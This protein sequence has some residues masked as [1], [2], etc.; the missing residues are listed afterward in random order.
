MLVG[1]MLFFGGE[2]CEALFSWILG[3][4][5]LL[6]LLDKL[7]LRFPLLIPFKAIQLP[8]IKY[9][10]FEETINIGHAQTGNITVYRSFFSSSKYKYA[11]TWLNFIFVFLNYL[12]RNLGKALGWVLMSFWTV[13]A[14]LA[15]HIH[16]LAINFRHWFKC[17]RLLPN[18]D[19][20]ELALAVLARDIPNF[21]LINLAQYIEINTFV[22]AVEKHWESS[23]VMELDLPDQIARIYEINIENFY[24]AQ[25]ARDKIRKRNWMI[26]LVICGIFLSPLSLL[27][28][29]PRYKNAF[30]ED[31]IIRT[32]ITKQEWNERIVYRRTVNI[33]K[34]GLRSA[35]DKY[36]VARMMLDNNAGNLRKIYALTHM[37]SV[38]KLDIY[39][40]YA[41]KTQVQKQNGKA[42]IRDIVSKA[43]SLNASRSGNVNDTFAENMLNE[44]E[45]IYEKHASAVWFSVGKDLIQSFLLNLAACAFIC[46][47]PRKA[48]FYAGKLVYSELDTIKQ[49]KFKQLIMD[50]SVALG[51]KLAEEMPKVDPEIDKRNKEIRILHTLATLSLIPESHAEDDIHRLKALYF[52]E[53]LTGGL[54]GLNTNAGRSSLASIK[55]H[56]GYV[57]LTQKLEETKASLLA[58]F[59]NNP[60]S[61]NHALHF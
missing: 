7:Q 26:G 9:F 21:S 22:A 60:R 53:L 50:V 44:M 47:A 57:D 14:Y 25:L 55:Q 29:I 27:I 4:A 51:Q 37:P 31:G 6:R 35:P 40:Q 23:K 59:T 16:L 38:G 24:E 3:F 30:R 39:F 18:V 33:A 17:R 15:I 49:G 11:V 2:K 42:E 32:E 28:M 54:Y 1:R 46:K 48:I 61:H 20:N 12:A 8:T 52:S 41:T 58:S 10:F 45:K 34:N 5:W 56:T 13:P 36:H 19:K 43:A